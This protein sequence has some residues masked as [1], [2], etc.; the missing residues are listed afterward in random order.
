MSDENSSYNPKE[1]L[2]RVSAK[3]KGLF[4]TFDTEFQNDF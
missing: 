4:K 3:T 1:D 2:V